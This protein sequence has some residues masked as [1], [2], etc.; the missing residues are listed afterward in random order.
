MSNSSS[1]VS[2]I[3]D[4]ARKRNAV[5]LA[6]NY[7]RGDVQDAADYLGD[8]LEL[9]QNAARIN[10][11]VIVFCGVHFMAETASI[12]SPD[13][14]VLTP[15]EDAGCRMADMISVDRLRSLKSTHPDATVVSYVNSTAAVKAESD[16]CCTSANAVEVIAS[17]EAPEIIFVPDKYLAAYVQTKVS[18]KIIPW[19]GYCPTHVKILPEDVQRQ[20]QLHPAAKVIVHP[21]CTPPVIALADDVLSTGGMCKY[22][23]RSSAAEIIV[24]TEIGLL[25]RL[26]KENPDKVFYAASDRAVCPNMKT[27]TLPKLLWAL[28]EKKTEVK[29]PE[30]IR[31]KAKEA[32]DRMLE[33]S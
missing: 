33:V 1:I 7:Q 10:T 23:S 31:I 26:R 11:D 15:D 16:V 3:R 12:L 4:L 25:H 17:I 32:L 22:A 18:R 24:G 29:V 28:Q 8:S 20:K 30:T 2:K 5:I 19:S 9:S 14:V 13:K 27:I 6:H 21:E